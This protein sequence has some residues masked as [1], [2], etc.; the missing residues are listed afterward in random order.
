MYRYILCTHC[1][2]YIPYISSSHTAL[3]QRKIEQY[4][5]PLVVRVHAPAS[6]RFFFF[7]SHI[8]KRAQRAKN[9]IIQPKAEYC[10][11]FIFSSTFQLYRYRSVRGSKE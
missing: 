8:P 1:T 11:S 7:A 9:K 5:E 10:F 4:R 3:D 6:V 2:V